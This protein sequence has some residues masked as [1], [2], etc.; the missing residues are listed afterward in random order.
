METIHKQ[1]T[2]SITLFHQIC[3]TNDPK[4]T[5]HHNKNFETE[6]RQT[7]AR[8]LQKCHR[9]IRRPDGQN[10]HT[11]TRH[12]PIKPIKT[13]YECKFNITKRN[14]SLYAKIPSMQEYWRQKRASSLQCNTRCRPA[15]TRPRTPRNFPRLKPN[16]HWKNI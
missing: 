12:E 15:Q 6:T 14:N 10:T 4:T 9:K 2:N 5:R 13:V 8:Q 16:S 3:V 11:H 1:Q 7:R